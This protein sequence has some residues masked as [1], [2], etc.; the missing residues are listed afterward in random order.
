MADDLTPDDDD[1][2]WRLEIKK[3]DDGID[4]QTASKDDLTIYCR[5]KIKD[6]ILQNTINIQLWDYF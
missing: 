4:L 1:F 5:A 2:N 6:Y 3:W